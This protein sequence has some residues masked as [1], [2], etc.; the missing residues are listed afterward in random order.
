M[1]GYHYLGA[2]IVICLIT[3]MG[4]FSGKKVKTASDFDSGSRKTGAGIVMGSIF[5][6]LVGGASTI[7]TAQLAY[8]HGFSAWWFTLGAGIGCLTLLLFYVK[9]FYNSH[10][11]TLPEIFSREYGETTR[12]LSTVLTS[13]GNFLTIASQVLSGV[14]L[15]TAILSIHPL[16]ASALIIGLM[17]IYVMFGGVWGVGMVGIIKTILLSISVAICGVLAISA[18]G[19]IEGFT[20]VLTGTDYFNLLSRGAV[21]DL[22]SGTSLIIG[23]MTT[24]AYIQAVI[25]AKSLKDSRLGVLICVVL[26]PLIGIAGIFVGMYMKINYPNIEPSFALPIFVIEKLPA[27]LSGMVL[28]TLLVTIIGTGSGIALGIGSMFSN[29]LYKA[30]INKNADDKK[31]L[32]VNRLIISVVLCITVVIT[33]G[34]IGS[35]I[36]DWSYLSMGFRGAVAFLPLCTALFMPGKIPTLFINV[37]MIISPII[38]I[39]GKFILPH[40]IDPLF[41]GLLASFIAL[42]M[43]YLV[44]IHKLDGPFGR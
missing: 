17:L 32:F 4:V 23:V 25:S 31:L 42:A 11:K 39:I 19:G 3:F 22:G 37:S 6:S 20:S 29:D 43:G 33:F 36:L 28:A 16:L 26:I 5:G 34:N 9:P 35:L 14:A 18:Q 2:L 13:M 7:G 8:S 38:L 30:H 44:R 15:V 10:I 40:N 24:Q 12:T 1:T 21:L 27:L 41:L